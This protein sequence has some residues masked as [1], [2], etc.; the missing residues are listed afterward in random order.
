MGRKVSLK[1]V[2]LQTKTET[3]NEAKRGWHVEK[4]RS[5]THEEMHTKVQFV[6]LVCE[7]VV[8]CLW[9]IELWIVWTPTHEASIYWLGEE[10]EKHLNEK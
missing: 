1:V 3:K 9:R 6:L 2:N 8:R 4:K 7:I 5:L 10:T